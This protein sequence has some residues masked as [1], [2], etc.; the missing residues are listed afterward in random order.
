MDTAQ[1]WRRTYDTKGVDEVSWYQ[2]DPAVSLRLLT[3]AGLSPASRVLDV[4]GGASVLADRLL[5]AGIGDVTVLDIADSALS[6]ARTRLGERAGA[7]TWLVRD[8]LAWN[9]EP[10][11]D[12][13]HDR[14][15]FHFL[16][17]PADRDRYRRV[18]A[19]GLAPGGHVVIGTFAADGPQ[20]CSGLPVA[21]YDADQLAAQFPGFEPIESAREEH[22]TPWDSVQPFT[23]LVLRRR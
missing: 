22:H 18:L 10:R 2:T 21:R 5:D 19:A 12:L 23:W 16:T 3:A 6:A 4:G 15:V 9:P 14:A 17:D 1:H 20:S 11:Y 8:V 7:V 13:W